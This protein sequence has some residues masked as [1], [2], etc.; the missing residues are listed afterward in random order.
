MVTSGI[1]KK[2]SKE[3]INWYLRNKRELPWRETVDPYPI[4]LSEII[5]QQTRVQQGL[6][7]YFSFL[8]HFPTVNDLANASEKQILSLWQGLGYY[9]RA[10]N[11]HKTAQLVVSDYA[12]SF[13][14]TYI[15]LLKLKGVGPYT[16]AAIASFAF[17]EQVAVVDGNVYRVLTRIFGIYE[18]ITLNTTKKVIAE[19]AQ[20]LVPQ[21]LPD[22]YNQA[23]MEFGA[24]HCTPANPNCSTCPFA[25]SCVANAAGD[26]KI[27]PIKTK[28]KAK[29]ERF[30]NYFMVRCGDE[31]LMK[32]RGSNDIW[33]G[34]FEFLLFETKKKTSFSGILKIVPLIPE[35]NI[36]A[37]YGPY[38][39]I[40]S[41]QILHATFYSVEV[42]KKQF[43]AIKKE[44]ALEEVNIREITAT[45]KPVLITKYLKAHKF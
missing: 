2:F 18:D 9:S 29:Q 43:A 33:Q 16:A 24:M 11:L 25:R 5:L 31:V 36:Q 40:L 6:P 10:R 30:F 34:L 3:L 12:G 44:Y 45:P 39:H 8:K 4:W 38:K 27:L 13:P 37:E 28:A 41:H 26:Q 17:K 42:T 14:D 35:K 1:E 23:I 20:K 7:Y 22:I 21:K 15:N 32:E 19:L